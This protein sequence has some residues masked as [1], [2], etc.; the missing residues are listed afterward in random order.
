M[1]AFP[2]VEEEHSQV[3]A[4]VGL[5]HRYPALFGWY[6]AGDGILDEVHL[7][8]GG[9]MHFDS[10]FRHFGV[11]FLFIGAKEGCAAID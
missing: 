8:E 10:G 6:S 3:V 4:A 2:I 7:L 5:V 1:V 9:A 11:V